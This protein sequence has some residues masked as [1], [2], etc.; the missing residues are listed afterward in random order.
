[1]NPPRKFKFHDG[2][3]GSSLAVRVTPRASK[4][5]VVEILDDGTIRIRLTASPNDEESNLALIAFLAS[6]VDVDPKRLEIVAGVVGR[7]KLIAVLD[8]DAETV[9]Q[10][11]IRQ[12]G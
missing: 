12:L 8:L 4:N 6:V 9:H 5:E 3:S 1:M 10:R 7:D 11:I 2:K